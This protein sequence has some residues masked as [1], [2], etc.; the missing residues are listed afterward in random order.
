MNAKLIITDSYFNIFPLLNDELKGRVNDLTHKNF[1]FCEEK[2]S[3]M[4]ERSIAAAFSGTLNTEVYSFGNFL[5]AE[6]PLNGLLSKEGSAM[7]IKKILS[8]VPLGCFKKGK[9]NLSSALFELISQLKSAKIS[10]EE[11]GRAA[12]STDGILSAKLKDVAK[13]YFA[14][15]KYI[16]DNNL[17]DQSSAL[18]LLP[19][20][21][22]NSEKI[23]GARVFIVGFSGFT[24]QLRQAIT[25]LLS[26][27]E[28]CTAIL[29][30]GENGFAFVN[31]AAVSF[32]SIC[33]DAG[34]SVAEKTVLSDYS[35]G[36]KIIKDGLFNPLF[37]PALSFGGK[38]PQAHFLAAK[39]VNAEAERIAE[40]IKRKVMEEN[41]RYRD[42]TVIIKSGDEY[43]E[44][45]KRNFGLLDIPYFLDVKKK[46]ENF[47]AAALIYAYCDLFIR[48]LKIPALAAFFKNPYLSSDKNF[49]DRFENYLY[50]YDICYDKFKKPFTYPADGEDLALFNEFRAYVV[51][52]LEGFNVKS[53]LDRLLTDDKIEELSARLTLLNENED[54]E[55]NRQ[56]AKKVKE[57]IA[58]MKFVLGD[59]KYD[60]L[61]FKSLFASG[62]AAMEVSVIPQYNDAVFIG[63]FKRAAAAKSKYL[64]AANLTGDVPDFCEDVALL[65]DGDID[66]LEQIKL[67][68]EPKIQVVNHR[69]REDV[70]LGLSAYKDGL[71]LSYP[72]SDFTGAAT[73]KSEILTFAE[74]YFD[75]KKFPPYD[76]YTT[77]KQGMRTFSRDCGRFASLFIDDFSA[78]SAFY[79]ATKGAP[80][81]IVNYAN[82]EIKV[83]LNGKSGALINGVASPTVIEDY[84][85]CPYR[86]F[87][88]HTLKVKERETGK[89][90]ALSVGNLMHEIFRCFIARV[91]EATDREK[92]DIL[93]DAIAAEII[94]R[95][96]YAK[97]DDAESSIGLSLALKGCKQ[98]CYNLSR[99]YFSSAF[100]PRKNGLEVKFGGDENQ[101]EGYPAVNLSGGKIKLSGKIDRVDECGD[102]FRI[103]DYKTGGTE[104]SDEKIFTGQKLQLYLYSLAITDKILAGAYYLRVNDDY[105][106]GG[107]KKPPLAEGKTANDGDFITETEKE[108]IP[109]DGKNKAVAQSTLSAVQKYVR[110]MAEQA[111]EQLDKGVIIPS[112]YSG[113]CDYCDFAPMC[114]GGLSPRKVSG[115]DTAL[116]EESAN[117]LP[118]ADK[119][120]GD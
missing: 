102:Y 3:L 104:V 59:F 27:A 40:V 95:D 53:L 11:L 78:Q 54:A 88:I 9:N 63:D 14:Y 93:F 110:A 84:Y 116:I 92:S 87:I 67:L 89:V 120:T 25:A 29:T 13:V 56:S 26:R 46:P 69:V 18:S 115:V 19:E 100:K 68:I 17:S 85:A 66:A 6:K 23:K 44:A 82:K 65:S 112:P 118:S 12:D 42:F 41:L 38:K 75:L 49:T 91:D 45:I 58:E 50:K 108:F 36:G 7:A 62:M 32:R 52:F 35:A 109:F 73:V 107:D 72:L 48:G 47:P 64:F 43:M 57:L 106:A 16:A 30:G 86:S 21:I 22:L 111:A 34:V 31:E 96:E 101:S 98:Y 61:E 119:K 15:E 71:Y 77:K 33:A 80:E 10:P 99:W 51:S 28:S 103:I 90:N 114:R 5:R 79:V 94:K 97:F 1:V 83:R 24:V 81:R 60:A 117:E 76:G 2:A 55:I 20:I 4:A 105:R 74:K 39:S 8:E 37:K 113:T 70:A